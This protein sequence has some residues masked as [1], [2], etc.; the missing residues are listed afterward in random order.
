MNQQEF[1][2]DPPCLIKETK[3][4]KKQWISFTPALTRS[5]GLDGTVLCV[6]FKAAFSLVVSKSTSE[7]QQV[8]E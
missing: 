5:G 7:K 3:K 6:Q 1:H 4:K 2:K 8:Y